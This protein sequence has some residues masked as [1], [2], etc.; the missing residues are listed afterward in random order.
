MPTSWMIANGYYIHDHADELRAL[1]R[2]AGR[3]SDLIKVPFDVSEKTL[4]L[5]VQVD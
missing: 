2:P 1:L 3:R 5:Y 4:A